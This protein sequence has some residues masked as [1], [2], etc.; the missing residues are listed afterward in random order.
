MF[1]ECTVEM[2]NVVEMPNI[3]SL[4]ERNV[5]QEIPCDI[6]YLDSG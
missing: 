5:S 4:V 3:V 2:S 1:M 6:W